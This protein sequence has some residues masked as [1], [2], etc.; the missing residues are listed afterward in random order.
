[1]DQQEFKVFIMGIVLYFKGQDI[2]IYRKESVLYARLTGESYEQLGLHN[3]AQTCKMAGIEKYKPIIERHF[4]MIIKLRRTE[5]EV[6]ELIESY[7]FAK[8]HLA[9][10]IYDRRFLGKHPG[11]MLISRKVST[12]LESVVVIDMPDY[13]MNIGSEMLL[14]WRVDIDDIYE[15][16]MENSKMMYEFKIDEDLEVHPGVLLSVNLHHYTANILLDKEFMSRYSDEG[17]LLIGV[18]NRHAAIMLPIGRETRMSSLVGIKEVNEQFYQMGPGS[19]TNRF[20]L[21]EGGRLREVELEIRD[22]SYRF[23]EYRG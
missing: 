6:K 3:L 2:P 13:I 16:A 17:G 1:M 4:S 22:S 21:Y 23:R 14:K 7:D 12:S 5:K 15:Q 20:L 8:R 11:S 19:L 10:K 9:L 18:P